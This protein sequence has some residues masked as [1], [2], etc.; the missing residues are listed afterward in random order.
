MCPPFRMMQINLDISE[1]VIIHCHQ[2]PVHHYTLQ[3][4]HT[5]LICIEVNQSM[6][7]PFDHRWGYVL[8]HSCSHSPLFPAFTVNLFKMMKTLFKN[9]WRPHPRVPTS[10]HD[11][12]TVCVIT[13]A[14]HVCINVENRCQKMGI[15]CRKL[16]GRVTD[17]AK[18]WMQKLRLHS[19]SL[20]K[21]LTLCSTSNFKDQWLGSDSNTNETQIIKLLGN[22]DRSLIE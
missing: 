5:V 11:S 19:F 13:L 1:N 18:A 9:V 6:R 3:S 17:A 21:L 12:C 22:E 15:Q 2:R 16:L 7:F 20:I 10:T 8:C 14:L 4:A